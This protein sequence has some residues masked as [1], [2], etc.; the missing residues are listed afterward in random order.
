MDLRVLGWNNHYAQLFYSLSREDLVP[1]RV[2]SVDRSSFNL[3]GD[4][5]EV[6]GKIS[7]RYRYHADNSNL[8]A[9]GDWV[10]VSIPG[11]ANDVVVIHDLL[12]R[13]TCLARKV[14]GEVTQA[15]VIAAN[16]DTVFI[17]TGLDNNFNVRR[18]ERYI[19]LINNSHAQPVVILNKADLIRD[20]TRRDEIRESISN[21]SGDVPVHFISLVDNE[22]LDEL[23]FYLIPGQTIALVGSSGVG[24]ST[25]TNYFLG[26]EQQRVFE[27]RADDSRGRHTTTRRQLF[28]LPSNAMLIDTPGMREIQLWIDGDQFNSGF[29]D[30][31]DLQE[32]CKFSDCTHQN[33]PGCAVIDAIEQG[34]IDPERLKSFNKMQR[35]LKY[36]EKRQNET[37]WDSRLADRQFGKLRNTMLRPKK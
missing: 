2:L 29:T 35:E 22:G 20:E 13:S 36:L 30:I 12:E 21:L 5:G 3:G 16:V 1:A 33:E 27:T 26:S 7:G 10:A 6:V 18:I 8:P 23:S 37:G 28:L 9:V 34:L 14:A 32:K 15:Q 19:T 25:L 31:D 24:K 11:S 4:F 17:V